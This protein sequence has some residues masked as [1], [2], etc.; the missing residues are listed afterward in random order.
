[1]KDA[2][3]YLKSFLIFFLVTVLIGSAAGVL[4]QKKVEDIIDNP[5]FNPPDVKLV[6]QLDWIVPVD[7]PLFE[8]FTESERVNILCLGVNQGMTDVI[9]VASY[10]IKNQKIDLISVPR[11]TYYYREG[12]TGSAFFK[13]NSIYHTSGKN[14]KGE[15]KDPVAIA[16]AVSDVLQGMPIN[17][18][19]VISF[20]SVRTIINAMGG[21]D[22][23]IP[24]DMDYDDPYDTPPLSIHFK[25][26]PYHFD[27]DDA[28]KY[29]RFR[30]DYIDGD[31]GRIHAQQEFIKAAFKQMLKSNLLKMARV[32]SD[33]VETDITWGFV[34]SVVET[35]T[36]F[37]SD[38][39][40][41]Y[42]MPHTLQ[43]GESWFVY[44][45]PEEIVA[46]IKEIYL[47]SETAA[48]GQT[49]N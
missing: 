43:I 32:I 38:S 20:D 21:V 22:Y 10:D 47:R 4:L 30:A 14:A 44:P 25:A 27:G 24:Q 37:S 17:Y 29:L 28:L 9:I 2:K 7:S 34:K 12:K 5:I 11:D 16:K 46:M 36:N 39:L 41:T 31:I 19:A 1:M 6:D 26:G 23:D 40:S 45:N 33:N 15:N 42:T 8:T 13:I 35:I 48:A 18:Y 49:A 3:K